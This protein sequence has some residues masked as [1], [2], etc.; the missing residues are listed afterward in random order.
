MKTIQTSTLFAIM[1][2]IVACGGEKSS[3]EQ[4]I[5]QRDSLRSEQNELVSQINELEIQ[6]AAM[7]TTKKL[8]QVTSQAI[9][10][11]K[12]EHFFDIYGDV[13]ADQNVQLYSQS[14]GEILQVLVK[15]GDQVSQGQMLMKIDDKIIRKNVEQ[16]ETQLR[17]A[18]DVF[19]RQERLWEK[20]I[21]S[22]MQYLEAKNAKEAL[23]KQLEATKAQMDQTV[24]TAPFSGVIDEIF[25]KMGEMASPGMP[26]VRLVNLDEVYIK[27]D[28]SEKYV[29]VVKRGTDVQVDFPD[30]G[31]SLD[32]T[33]S[34]TGQ[35]INP[36]NRT[37]TVR[38]A[39]P[40]DK[41]ALKPNLLAVL[42]VKD[43][44]EDNAVVVP[45]D[46]IQQT[47]KGE[48]FVYVLENHTGSFVA[49]RVIVETGISYEGNTHILKGLNGTEELI[50]DGARS[51]KDGQVVD[52]TNA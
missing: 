43:F 45:S 41:G 27:A 5:A 32:T 16:I 46:L 52:R 22:E 2:F 15:E 20:N 9:S 42:K 3:L 50:R 7:D 8:V 6:I 1:A 26:L 51:V 14:A 28:V 25:P 39:L 35:Y 31:V 12:F 48:S 47:A 21:G 19:V 17:L 10:R 29:A 18:N 23:Q 40:N 24:I 34:L 49:K 38:V 13:K 33:I 36:M 37:F 11:Q 30:L 44:E 4:M